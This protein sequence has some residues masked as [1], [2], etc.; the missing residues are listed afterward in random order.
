MIEW[1]MFGKQGLYIIGD[2]GCG[3]TTL[4]NAFCKDIT[5]HF[6]SND[7]RTRGGFQWESA[8]TLCD[9]AVNNPERLEEFKNAEWIAIDDLGQ[10]PDEVKNYGTILKPIEEI[11][12]YR[13]NRKNT[14]DKHRMMV[15]ICTTNLTPDAIKSKYGVRVADRMAE[16]MSVMYIK[17]KSYRR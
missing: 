5:M 17:E 6:Y 11:L 4:L 1:S 13:Y 2:V 14:I 15:T 8:S 9:W 7:S 16:I 3:K 12:M 10:E